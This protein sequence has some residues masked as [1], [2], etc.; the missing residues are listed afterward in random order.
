MHSLP[1]PAV[2]GTATKRGSLAL[3]FNT[4]FIFEIGLLGLATLAPQALAVSIT[5][6]PPKAISISQE[7]DLYKLNASSTT[8]IVGLGLI[9]EKTT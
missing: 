2:V 7:A 3:T 5:E 1:V 9:L 6:P 8:S 4:P